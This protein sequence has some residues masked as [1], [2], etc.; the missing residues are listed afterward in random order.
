ML[1]PVI[2]PV[3]VFIVATV[4]ELLLQVPPGVASVAKMVEPIHTTPAL[5]IG[6]GVLVTLS[7]LV[8]KQPVARL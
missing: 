7:V 6:A 5:D 3:D 1:T 4:V 8:L 2:T